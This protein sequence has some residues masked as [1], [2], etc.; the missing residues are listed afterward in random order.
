MLTLL[1]Q[2]AHRS[3]SGHGGWPLILTLLVGLFASC[4]IFVRNVPEDRLWRDWRS[5]AAGATFL[6]WGIMTFHALGH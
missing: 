5:Y 6:V 4:L 3:I 1:C 2:C